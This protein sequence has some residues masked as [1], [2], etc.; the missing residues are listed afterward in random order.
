[1]LI[2]VRGY[3]IESYLKK[4]IV[5]QYKFVYC[6]VRYIHYYTNFY[7][8]NTFYT[9]VIIDFLHIRYFS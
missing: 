2:T 7:V 3:T 5:I 9:L 4:Y 8:N 1:M 6:V